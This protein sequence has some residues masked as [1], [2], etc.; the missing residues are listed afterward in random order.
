[1]ADARAVLTATDQLLKDGLVDNL[2]ALIRDLTAKAEECGSRMAQAEKAEKEAKD[3]R[4][5]Q[6]AAA[7]VGYVA[8]ATTPFAAP[9][10]ATGFG[11]GAPAPAAGF[12]AAPA[13]A[14]GAAPTAPG[15]PAAPGVL[16]NNAPQ[17]PRGYDLEPAHLAFALQQRQLAS[18]VLFYVC[19][20]T[21]LR[22]GEV[23]ALIDLVRD[24]TNGFGEIGDKF[25]NGVGCGLRMLDPIADAPDAWTMAA[26]H[27][28]PHDAATTGMAGGYPGVAAAPFG[29]QYPQQQQPLP[30]QVPFGSVGGYGIAAAASQQQPPPFGAP[31]NP[32]APA[33]SPASSAAYPGQPLHGT[34]QP[35][36]KGVERWREELVSE[37]W[38][39]RD[40]NVE[41]HQG[42]GGGAGG[43]TTLGRPHLLRCAGTLVLCCLCAL[44]GGH[45]LMDR[46]LHLPNRFGAGNALLPPPSETGAVASLDDL[47]PVHSRLDPGKSSKSSSSSDAAPASSS[48]DTWR[49]QDVL[50]LLSA[51]YGL[52]LRP[53]AAVLASPKMG[54]QS[55]AAAGAGG[56][57]S[58]STPQPQRHRGSSS[59]GGGI[60]V[61]SSF[62]YCLEVP[63]LNKSLTFAR[64]SLL[65]SLGVGASSESGDNG[66]DS[67]HF[68][69]CASVLSEF[70]A[71]YLD[72]VCAV[73]F[74]PVSR[75]EW[76]S[77]EEKELE[78]RR[79]QRA[80]YGAWGG[81]GAYHTTH[82]PTAPAEVVD[83]TKRPDCMDDVLALASELCAVC[84]E[85]AGQFWSTVEERENPEESPGDR[86][87]T[88]VKIVPSRFL[89]KLD[90]LRAEDNSLLPAYLAFLSALSLA[91]DVDP[92]R[93]TK[94]GA[95]AVHA[96]LSDRVPPPLWS[97]SSSPSSSLGASSSSASQQMITWSYLLD[98]VRYYADYLGSYSIGDGAPSPAGRSG[99]ASSS[100][101][102][103]DFQGRPSTAYYYGAESNAVE[104]GRGFVH[105]SSDTSMGAGA[106]GIAG[107]TR[108]LGEA[109]TLTLMSILDLISRAALRSPEARE[110]ILGV[111]L[112]VPGA[113]A[114]VGA[115]AGAEDD[116][117]TILFSLAIQPLTPEV[118]GLAFVA[119]ANLIR[120]GTR[121]GKE[122]SSKPFT[123][124]AQMQGRNDVEWGRRGWEMLEA[125]RI[126]PIS[127]LAQ[128]S[129]PQHQ[130]AT[131]DVA[132]RPMFGV[133]TRSQSSLAT[134]SAS[135]AWLPSSSEYGILYEME[136][137]E[138]VDGTYPSTEGFLC[139]LAALIDSAGCPPDLGAPIAAPTAI[140]VGVSVA[141][142]QPGGNQPQQGRRPGCAPYVEYVTDFVLPRAVGGS[143]SDDEAGLYFAAPGDKSRLISRALEVVY[144]AL[145]RYVVPPPPLP[146]ALPTTSSAQF[147]QGWQID[148][149]SS[150]ANALG[151]LTGEVAA[152]DP[153]AM[154]PAQLEVHHERAVRDACDSRGLSPVRADL[155]FGGGDRSPDEVRDCL[156]DFLD[157][158]VA[159]AAQLQAA[160]RPA[161]AV[162]PASLR[163]SAA[164]QTQIAA[165]ASL[166]S[167]PS[168][169]RAKSPGFSILASVLSSNGGGDGRGWS[170]FRALSEIL[171]EGG[172]ADG[173]AAL[174]GRAERSRNAALGLYG[175]VPPD[176]A[177]SWRRGPRSATA[178]TL[179]GAATAGTAAPPTPQEALQG[180]MRPLSPLMLHAA[181]VDAPPGTAADSTLAS[182]Y[183]SGDD[184]AAWRELSV[185]LSLRVLCAVAT[186]EEA[187]VRALHGYSA[188]AASPVGTGSASSLSIV[189]ALRFR[190]PVR[191]RAP[192]SLGLD[193]RDVRV[194][195]LVSL[196]LESPGRS[197]RAEELVPVLARYVGY[198][199][200]RA[201]NEGGGGIARAAI[202]L[203]SL[204]ART[205]PHAECAVAL[206]GR[207]DGGAGRVAG[208]FAKRLLAPS[209]SSTSSS[210][211]DGGDTAEGPPPEKD[212]P[213]HI[214][215]SM[216]LESLNLHAAGAGNGDGETNLALILLGLGDSK[217]SGAAKR[218]LALLKN[219]SPVSASE[220]DNCLEA[221][222][223]LVSDLNFVL[224]PRTS[225]LAARCYELA[226]RLCD[227]SDVRGV[228][229]P[230]LLKLR[231]ADYWIE[232]A[233]R[234]LSGPIEGGGAQRQ[235]VL[236]FISACAS[237]ADS[238]TSL[239]RSQCDVLHSIA[240]LLRGMAVELH[241]LTGL[242][243]PASVADDPGLA[244]LRAAAAPQPS[245][246]CRTL[247]FLFSGPTFAV[248][249]ALTDLPLATPPFTLDLERGTPPQ[250]L[251]RAATGV[252]EGPR[253]VCGGHRIVD[254]RVL[255][256]LLR[257]SHQGQQDGSPLDT[258]TAFPSS[259]PST[260]QEREAIAWADGWNLY[261]SYSCA[262]SHLSGGW[263]ELTGSALAS[264][265]SLLFDDEAHLSSGGGEVLKREMLVELTCLALSRLVADGGHA[266]SAA[267]EDGAALPLSIAA[268]RLVSALNDLDDSRA[269]ARAAVSG[270]DDAGAEN[271]AAAV[272]DEERGRVG[273]LLAAAIASCSGSGGGG[274]GG[275]GAASASAGGLRAERAAVL[276]CALSAVLRCGSPSS[277][278]EEPGVKLSLG[279][280]GAYLSAAAYL[281][282]VAAAVVAG[283]GGGGDAARS[284]KARAVSVAARSGLTDIVAHFNR[285]EKYS[286][287]SDGGRLYGTPF[288][289]HLFGTEASG[290]GGTAAASPGRL[291]GLVCLLTTYDEDAPRCLERIACC[292]RGASLLLSAGT[293]NA[294]VDAAARYSTEV[295]GP[296]GGTF[297]RV[298]SYG[299]VF[300]APPFLS[301]HLTLLNAMLSSSDADLTSS[302]RRQ[303]VLDATKLVRWYAVTGD[304]LLRTFPRH[305]DVTAKFV[306]C[307]YLMSDSMAEDGDGARGPFDSSSSS[308]S[309]AARRGRLGL[310]D[311]LQ[312]DDGLLA[313]LDRLI[314]ELAYHLSEFPFPSRLLP[315]LPVGLSAVERARASRNTSAH[316]HT[317][318]FAGGGEGGS[319][320]DD[321]ANGTTAVGSS[322]SRSIVLPD[323]PTGSA[324]TDGRRWPTATGGPQDPSVPTADS[325]SEEKYGLAITAARCLES[326]LLYLTSRAE[327]TSSSTIP[328]D[329]IAL[330]KGLC[331]C[332]DAARAIGERLRG[333]QISRDAEIADMMRGASLSMT[334]SHRRGSNGTT[335]AIEIAPLLVLGPIFGR[336]A[337]NVLLLLEG[338][339]SRHVET[340]AAGGRGTG[341][342]RGPSA[343]P[344]GAGEELVRAISP[345]ME[346]TQIETLGIRCIGALD[347][348]VDDFAR[349][350][351]KS[352][353]AALE[354]ISRS[355]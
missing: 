218:R 331:R 182:A 235:S 224:D 270:G 296:D 61:K 69:F 243:L 142:V 83:L 334:K 183:V 40:P 123:E 130:D 17:K 59:D 246:C 7:A 28:D 208:A 43:A 133:A 353:G 192:S 85:C 215:L 332:S 57:F 117:L 352:I 328:L 335:A 118:R 229:L 234:L 127:A 131:G 99:G 146:A 32:Y 312:G 109:N 80:Q 13:L 34:G 250:A 67:S 121:T 47:G 23:A 38:R 257:A 320:W 344:A 132:A 54:G 68:S 119:I 33:S 134:I 98:S 241:S 74:L 318:A 148:G 272:F 103:F 349:N 278:K 317:V 214:I 249:R 52:L 164:Q 284:E 125:S 165:A 126:L 75:A 184:A 44:D 281:S 251:I 186:R 347:S 73:G 45:V 170:L 78:L 321:A 248:A 87:R 309:S 316:A 313:R 179:Y 298:E 306:A 297:D 319:W 77:D 70:A 262:T 81:A 172:D 30:G 97:P 216:I 8:A 199:P 64:T 110:E 227:S 247:S 195:R 171:R 189:P 2:I 35:H 15:A 213:R 268:L 9:T 324:S 60:D 63:V 6:Q 152:G 58:F 169:P 82:A 191:G 187:F 290:G 166:S 322:G 36:E 16:N 37:A 92:S 340:V 112:P 265:R 167:A 236:S 325:W 21:Q 345:A 150:S 217:S 12:G 225:S 155:C 222:L 153:F 283:Q 348:G 201:S 200:H 286:D 147:R 271:P 209:S 329:S 295:Y 114:A 94:N 338:A 100:S 273:A 279:E 88:V 292:A 19:Y 219:P 11:F 205:V 351:A 239:T 22:P 160:G 90:R 144:L 159:E 140:P 10:P 269:A 91:G 106:S 212:D 177:A 346:H 237:S 242:S 96:L 18:D 287:D 311:L 120:G 337:S 342:R 107:A 4:A 29:G 3:Q 220:S 304:S 206:C 116:P 50:G 300:R 128:Y 185:L 285:I 72:A 259:S 339:L 111:R 20:G 228:R 27:N 260:D 41:K 264:C 95:A 280:R 261:S 173:I 193:V 231:V 137:V 230:V 89:K 93:P 207:E 56:S 291:A 180:M 101:M 138:A 5:A 327:Q 105:A 51:A 330:S 310:E 221:A 202:S 238:A 203:V 25:P 293:M 108:E 76:L 196:L 197:V 314:S 210:P 323:P 158:T 355:M 299:S 122:E 168:P 211:S 42:Q 188:A 175:D 223:H 48:H 301:G 31:P 194:A 102:A 258:S 181:F 151:A 289:V 350:V 190:A 79:Q 343:L 176:Y 252:L 277:S 282:D 66:L 136:Q 104:G 308:S 198:A 139:L 204:V 336:C 143:R 26:T 244:D 14:F 341:R 254:C 113:S 1:M 307:L 253:D 135:S 354:Q 174:Y 129:S 161:A 24:M 288:L 163:P 156:R 302:I 276:S 326:C 315:P 145:A 178:S 303:M 157:L 255:L 141:A 49:R 65:P 266:G 124:G 305:G 275:A 39:L 274:N 71:R 263:E 86:S 62:R 233:S 333:L 149:S 46:D 245:R 240:W 256:K 226:Y 115:G 55:P 162:P 84:P 154:S 294:L 267:L 232:H 53:S